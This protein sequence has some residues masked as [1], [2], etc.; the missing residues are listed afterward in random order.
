ME[1]NTVF[2]ISG[3]EK[4]DDEVDDGEDRYVTCDECDTQV[5]C[6]NDNINIV[7]KGGDSVNNPYEELVLCTMCFQDMKDELIQQ[8]YLCDDW[9]IDEEEP[10]EEE[11]EE[12]EPDEEEFK[13]PSCKL[14][15]SNNWCFTCDTHNSC[16]SCVGD[17]GDDNTEGHEEWICQKCFDKQPE[18]KDENYEYESGEEEEPEEEEPEEEEHDDTFD[19]EKTSVNDSLHEDKEETVKL[20]V[21]MD[22]E[23]YPPDWDSEEDTEETYQEDQWK[24][25]CLCDGYFNDDGMGD[26]L[27]VQEEPNNQEAGC[28]LCG[29]SDDVVQMKGCGQYLCGDGCDESDESDEEE[30]EEEGKRKCETCAVNINT[31]DIIELS[32]EVNGH[33]L[34]LCLCENC[35]QDKADI[36]R[37]EGWNVDDFFKEEDE[38]T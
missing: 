26:I 12:D 2:N 11:P 33:N 24:K 16:Q 10:E 17:G 38:D 35:F 27:F 34:K 25:C 32:I 9:D 30:E 19:E 3:V 15:Q 4:T 8:D 5:D 29:K 18:I 6:Y 23:R 31:D 22:C 37:K 28:S 13:C 14:V 20:C 21:N 36:L 7:Y 1:N